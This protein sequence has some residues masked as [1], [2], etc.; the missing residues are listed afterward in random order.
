MYRLYG[1]FIFTYVQVAVTAMVTKL[2]TDAFDATAALK[3]N[4]SGMCMHL[5]AIA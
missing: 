4:H 1:I 3:A 5:F 2:V